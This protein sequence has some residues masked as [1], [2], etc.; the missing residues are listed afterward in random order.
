MKPTIKVGTRGSTLA[1]C[2]TDLVVQR[3]RYAHPNIETRV[4]SINTFGDTA[5]DAPL[6]NLGL[7]VFV[8]EIEHL[9]LAGEIDLAVHSLKDLPT[10]LPEGLTLGAVLNRE[11]ARDVLVNK[12]SCPLSEVPAGARIGTSSPRREAQLK[13]LR[14]DLQVLPIRGNVETRLSKA[15]GP[16]YDGAILAAAGLVRLGLEGVVSEYLSYDDFVPAPGQGALT[17]EARGNDANILE[18]I[19]AIDHMPTRQEVTCERAF[20]EELG[21]GCS[22]PVGSYAT[23]HGKNMDLTVFMA[24]ADASS[25]FKIKVI[26]KVDAPLELARDAHQQLKDLGAGPLLAANGV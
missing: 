20:L 24:A 3:L 10:Q 23:S 12:W 14:P 18:M 9:L 2:Q 22:L 16:D 11:D 7:G 17:V 25:V 1:L 19:A 8:K 13:H 15:R 26:G 21:G 5:A 4:L 6:A